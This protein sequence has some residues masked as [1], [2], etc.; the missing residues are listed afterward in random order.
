MKKHLLILI[1]TLIIFIS[2]CEENPPSTPPVADFSKDT[3]IIIADITSAKF[4]N[5]STGDID[6]YSWE[7]EGGLGYSNSKDPSYVF[8]YEGAREVNLTV[9]GP[10][11]SDERKLFVVVY[12]FDPNCINF[13]NSSTHTTKKINSLRDNNLV[14]KGFIKIKNDYNVT[15]DLLLYSPADWLSGNYLKRYSYSLSPGAE[16]RLSVDNNPFQFSNEWGIRVQGTNGL[17]SCIRTVGA[18]GTF[19]G[20]QYTI[21][22][23]DI[24]DG[25]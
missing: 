8:E 17:I 3:D 19:N 21:R 2:A 24:L 14:K 15:L 12:P 5:T 25:I 6:S 16:G 18:V 11:G 22:A 4:D 23:S 1:G 10:G 7:F 13:N 9:E 20:S